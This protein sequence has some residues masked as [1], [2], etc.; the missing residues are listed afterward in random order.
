G[1][2]AVAAVP[3]LAPGERRGL[4]RGPVLP[5]R[6][7]AQR[8]AAPPAARSVMRRRGLLGTSLGLLPA[9]IIL[10]SIEGLLPLVLAYWFGR[11]AATDVLM[12]AWAWFTLAGAV[13]YAAFQDSALV[14]IVIELRVRRAGLSRFLG[15][16]F[17]HT[18]VAGV[19][20]A[21]IVA[22]A[23]WVVFAARWTGAERALAMALLA[24]FSAH[25]LLL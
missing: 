21:I 8:L 11:S 25:L 17:G 15:A 16:V 2:G 20:L 7:P 14:P 4:P 6:T 12:F 3:P 1:G 5:R 24:P 22:G 19:G 18:L 23:A 9:Q 13:L 10:R